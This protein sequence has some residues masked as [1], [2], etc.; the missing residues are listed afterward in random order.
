MMKSIVLLAL[1]G[2]ALAQNQKQDKFAGKYVFDLLKPPLSYS[3]VQTIMASREANQ[4]PTYNTIPQTS[5]EC[6]AK[7]Q[8]GFYAD[9]DTQCQVFHRC[10]QSGNRTD[11]LCPNTTVF[12][13]ITLICDS[14]YNVDCSRSIELE[15]FANSRLYT[16]LP[17]FD[18]P[19]ADYIAPYQQIVANSG[20]V[21]TRPVPVVTPPKRVV[22]SGSAS[23][24]GGGRSP[25]VNRPAPGGR[26][27]GDQPAEQAGVVN[28]AVPTGD[29]GA[30]SVDQGAA[31]AGADASGA[32]ESS[33]QS[34]AAAPTDQAAAAAPTDQ[35]A[36]AS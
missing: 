6:S 2:C 19:P 16:N 33:G 21:Q 20:S 28:I 15:D 34:A 4:Y 30:A 36:P 10:E 12:N 25:A 17:L 22:A 29:Q 1:V 32:A 35:A 5:F 14:F 26:T 24:R 23:S 3:E 13:Q 8:P 31:P 9:V 27:D 11:Y 7:A 18:T